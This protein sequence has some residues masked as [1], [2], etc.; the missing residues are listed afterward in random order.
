MLQ[1]AD[2]RVIE[3]TKIDWLNMSKLFCLRRSSLA[4]F[5][6]GQKQ[7]LLCFIHTNHEEQFVLVTAGNGLN[8]AAGAIKHRRHPR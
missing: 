6:V 7:S 1:F 8:D 2:D 5:S 3:I 4:A